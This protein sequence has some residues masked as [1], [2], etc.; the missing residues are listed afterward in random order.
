MM[1]RQIT[2]SVLLGFVLRD[3]FLMVLGVAVALTGVVYALRAKQMAFGRTR[4][5]NERIFNERWTAAMGLPKRMWVSA[6]GV[7]VSDALSHPTL[8]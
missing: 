4:K 7:S 5:V 1:H 2:S 6:E 3:S 8:A